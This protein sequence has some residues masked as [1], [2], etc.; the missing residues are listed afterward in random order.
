MLQSCFCH[1]DFQFEEKEKY[2]KKEEILRIEKKH[3]HQMEVLNNRNDKQ[4]SELEEMHVNIILNVFTETYIFFMQ[5]WI[6]YADY[7]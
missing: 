6:L 7:V 3:K 1:L 2:R 5:I 4:L